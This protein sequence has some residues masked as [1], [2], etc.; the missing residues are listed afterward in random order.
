MEKEERVSA[1][2]YAIDV[3]HI[4]G[5]LWKRV[6]IMALCG[7]LVGAAGFFYSTFVMKPTYSADIRLYVNIA[8]AGQS[9]GE[10]T[11]SP[12][13]LTAAKSLVKT[14]GAILDGRTTLERVIQESGVT[15]TWKELSGMIAY[16]PSNDT[17]IMRVTVTCNDP[18]EACSI[19]NT[20]AEVL[21]QRIEEIIDGTSMKVVDA[22]VP[23]LQK[24]GP[25]ISKYTLMGVVLGVV[26]CM[27]ILV[28]MAMLDGT[29]HD[30]EYVLQTYDYPILGKVPDLVVSGSKGYGYYVQYNERNG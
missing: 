28:I 14:Y 22:A 9:N 24:V 12:S 1:E 23:D 20:I 18:Y 29:V 7:L 10:M 6:W 11:I 25:S 27:V 26:L 2:Y 13:D 4:L 21:P 8:S 16:A 19:A 30:E 3:A 15:Y 5:F 17:Q